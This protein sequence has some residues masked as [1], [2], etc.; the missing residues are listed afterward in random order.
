MAVVSR[1]WGTLLMSA[2]ELA[3]RENRIAM[4]DGGG[5]GETSFKFFQQFF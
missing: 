2:V 4:C 1:W 5:H 3:R